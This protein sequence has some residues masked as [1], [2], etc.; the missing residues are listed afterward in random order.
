VDS[1]YDKKQQQLHS[2]PSHGCSFS[3]IL[4]GI[5]V[6]TSR[7]FPRRSSFD[8]G[9]SRHFDLKINSNCAILIYL[10]ELRQNSLPASYRFL[11]PKTKN[12]WKGIYTSLPPTLHPQVPEGS[13]HILLI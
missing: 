4:S 1:G 7:Q 12:F 5:D 3:T 9:N 6:I 13:L 8:K 11:E 10:K 2:R